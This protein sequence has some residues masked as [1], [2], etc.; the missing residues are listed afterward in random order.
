MIL[1][2]GHKIKNPTKTSKGVH[3]IPAK[4][5]IILTGTPVQNNLKVC[6]D[7]G[8]SNWCFPPQYFS[9]C[10]SCVL[11]EGPPQCRVHRLASLLGAQVCG[12]G[13]ST[14]WLVSV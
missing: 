8:G 6:V 11:V 10:L 3:A 14:D 9:Y 2:E 5:R 1:D 13:I 12:V 4:N 7:S